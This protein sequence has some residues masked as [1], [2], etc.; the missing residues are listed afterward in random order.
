MKHLCADII[1]KNGHRHLEI[2][3]FEAGGEHEM[4]LSQFVRNTAALALEVT[5]T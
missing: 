1:M 2:K 3:T 4:N 5:P